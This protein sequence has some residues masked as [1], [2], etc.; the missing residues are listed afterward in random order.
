MTKQVQNTAS[1]TPFDASQV[2]ASRIDLDKLI[3]EMLVK[4]YQLC[5][6]KY[7]R[8]SWMLTKWYWKR[9]RQKALNKLI[10]F[11]HKTND[12]SSI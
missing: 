10:E 2:E 12:T 4:R 9:Q 11:K 6:S 3:M 1:T 5:L 7:C 8:A